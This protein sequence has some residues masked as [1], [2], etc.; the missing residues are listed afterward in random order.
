MASLPDIVLPTLTDL[1]E[2]GEGALKNALPYDEMPPAKFAKWSDTHSLFIDQL[3][4]R[5]AARVAADP[6]FHYVLEDMERLRKKLDDNRISL[7]EDVRRHEVDEQKARKDAR[8]RTV[9]PGRRKN[10]AFIGS[11]WR[12]STHPNLN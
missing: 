8:S 4:A 2:F 10:R 1:P 3:K 9:S 6:E 7:N 5:S 11:H 12:R